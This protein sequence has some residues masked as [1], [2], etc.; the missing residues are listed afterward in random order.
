MYRVDASTDVDESPD[1]GLEL[2]GEFGAGPRAHDSAYWIDAFSVYLGC[3]NAGPSEC[4]ISINGYDAARS[5]R[6]ASQTVNQPACPGLTNCK[7]AKVS[8]NEEFRNL[9]GIQIIAAVDRR[10]VTWYMDELELGWS[11]N[12][13]EAS[14]ERNSHQ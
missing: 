2:I 1:S 12:T 7:L 4:V 9:T 10:P 13:C 6:V 8:L 3:N 14:I 5:T 11:N